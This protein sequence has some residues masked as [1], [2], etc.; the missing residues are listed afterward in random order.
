MWLCNMAAG[1]KVDL[2]YANTDGLHLLYIALFSNENINDE[3]KDV[4]FF[5]LEDHMCILFKKYQQKK[6]A[7]LN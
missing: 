5:F 7:T 2:R 1:L 3:N 6:P 4:S